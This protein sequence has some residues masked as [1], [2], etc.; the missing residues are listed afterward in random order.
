MSGRRLR[1]V[2]WIS[3][4]L[5][6]ACG[7]AAGTMKGLPR[8]G[9][10]RSPLLHW[11]QPSAQTSLTSLLIGDNLMRGH[12]LLDHLS[13]DVPFGTRTWP[14]NGTIAVQLHRPAIETKLREREGVGLSRQPPV[15][16][17][18]ALNQ[19]WL[20]PKGSGVIYFNGTATYVTPRFLSFPLQGC[21][22][23]KTGTIKVTAAA[24]HP[25][26]Y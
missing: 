13:P 25:G 3:A 16:A 17:H 23:P 7:P 11:R 1:L 9:R 10:H 22:W 12:G 6:A 15:V 20:S 26:G 4:L 18:F 2:G 14:T 19:V 8:H 5:L 21:Y 24:R